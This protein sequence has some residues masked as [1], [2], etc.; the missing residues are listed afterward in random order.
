MSLRITNKIYRSNLSYLIILLSIILISSLY[1]QDLDNIKIG[2]VHS[3]LTKNLLYAE[4]NNFYPVQDWELFFLNKKMS[5]EVFDD[6]GVDDYD[7][8]EVDVL[9]LPSIEVLSDDGFENLQNFLKE[10]NGLF[11]LG[12][13]GVK[14]EDGNNRQ[15]ELL[16]SLGGFQVNEFLDRNVIAKIHTVYANNFLA[17]NL[18]INTSFIVTNNFPLL[19]VENNSSKSLKLGEYISKDSSEDAIIDKSGIVKIENGKG[20]LLW[21]GFQLSQIS[22]DD[23]EKEALQKLI[24]NSISWLAGKPNAWVN[25]WPAELNSATVFISELAKLNNLTDYETEPFNTYSAESSFFISPSALKSFTGEVD[26]LASFGDIH[27][28]YDEIEHLNFSQDDKIA[29][30]ENAAQTLR[31]ETRQSFY[32]V[33]YINGN[34]QK[35]NFEKSIIKSFDFI[36]YEDYSIITSEKRRGISFNNLKMLFPPFNFTLQCNKFYKNNEL[37]DYKE[38]FDNVKKYGGI[39]PVNYINQY[40]QFNSSIKRDTFKK[41]LSYS[42][43]NYSWVTTYSGIVDWLIAKENISVNIKEIGEKPVF[44]LVI[45]NRNK[46]KVENVGIRLN[47]SSTYRNLVTVNSNF[48]LRYDALTRSYFLLVPILLANQSTTVEVHYDN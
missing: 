25:Q 29:T 45:E 6:E 38:H 39:I 30:L 17:H 15:L 3:S 28:L 47:I 23:D 43:N 8:D 48:S 18:Q 42:R 4:D 2:L 24:F 33:K 7:F 27:V 11:I 22:V 36:T 12:K 40:S 9:I 20:R 19:Y 41:I 46:D 10:G 37:A 34:R 16:Q 5:Y 26:R 21:F 1:P 44:K 13:L 35:H 14:D 32:G 31:S